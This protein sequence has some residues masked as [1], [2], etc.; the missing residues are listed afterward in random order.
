MYESIVLVYV[1]FHSWDYSCILNFT[2]NKKKKY[3]ITFFNKYFVVHNEN[4]IC[5]NNSKFIIC[6]KNEH[7][8]SSEE[9]DKI[10]RQDISQHWAAF[11]LHSV[12]P[13]SIKIFI[14]F[15]QSFQIPFPFPARLFISFELVA[16]KTQHSNCWCIFAKLLSL[17]AQLCNWI[18][19]L[20]ET[21]E[22]EDKPVQGVNSYGQNTTRKNP[23]ETF[24]F[25]IQR[26]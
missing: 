25:F 8:A 3:F 6:L 17:D 12:A 7:A 21:Y 4:V 20:T 22:R 16:I 15:L 10:L 5:C 14:I 2:G 13:S 9:Y 24:F 19:P 18:S 1:W 11:F 23:I 26:S